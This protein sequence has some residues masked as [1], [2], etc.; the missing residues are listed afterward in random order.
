[1]K[2][3]K[4]RE[5]ALIAVAGG[6]VAF[7]AFGLT[8]A[9]PSAMRALADRGV[10]GEV[11]AASMDA[12]FATAPVLDGAGSAAAHAAARAVKGAARLLGVVTP[13]RHAML[14]VLVAKVGRGINTHARVCV[15]TIMNTGCRAGG[16]ARRAPCL[17]H[18]ARRAVEAVLRPTAL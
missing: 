5:L 4:I 7:E 2:R 10:L 1:M 11:K 16:A 9:L 3:V 17:A 12:A 14:P 8:E 18:E 6:L 13:P 15:V